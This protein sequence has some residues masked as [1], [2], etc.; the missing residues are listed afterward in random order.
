VWFHPSFL[1]LSMHIIQSLALAT[2]LAMPTAAF[3]QPSAPVRITAGAALDTT[4]I[5]PRID[6]LAIMTAH[7][8]QSVRV[9][10]AVTEIRVDPPREE[11]YVIY[12]HRLLI[13]GQPP[14]VADSLIAF[15]GTLLP[16]RAHTRGDDPRN[17][18][19]STEG[20]WIISPRD[21][22]RTEVDMDALVFYLAPDL[23]L[24]ALPLRPGYR[25]ILPVL[26]RQ[27]RAGELHVRV[28]G[29]DNART[30]DGGTCPAL[31]VEVREGSFAGTFRLSTADRSVIRFDSPQ[32]TLVR[33]TGCP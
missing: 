20:V 16:R 27:D 24:R 29:E 13:D 17:F 10:T 6:S 32:A 3:G 18:Y 21:N 19:F 12:V 31:V 23:L 15:W 25:A 33:P 30:L 1:D 8:G 4:F 7:G 5:R 28:T 11:R 26:S 22:P 2:V 14:V 9:G